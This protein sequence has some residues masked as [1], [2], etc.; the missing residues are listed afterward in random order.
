MKGHPETVDNSNVKLTKRERTSHSK[1]VQQLFESLFSSS[2]YGFAICDSDLRFVEVNPAWTAIDGVAVEQHIGKTVPEV[3]RVAVCPVE[4]A[5]R[6][7]LSTGEPI[8]GLTFT[9]K[10][11]ARPE[12]ARWFV[13]LIP[14]IDECGVTTHVGS[15]TIE[16]TPRARF[17]SFLIA[18]TAQGTEAPKPQIDKH[19]LPHLTNREIEVIRLLAQEKSNKEIAVALKI[20]VKTVEAHRLRI[21]DRLGIHNLVGLT[22]FAIRH[23]LVI[24]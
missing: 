4:A 11:P 17:Q 3:L 15:I 13:S 24:L 18:E 6:R 8:F 10:I 21:M 20:S 1:Q 5:M 16:T 7:V 9:A 2:S 12:P 19:D 22:L 14:V 23:R